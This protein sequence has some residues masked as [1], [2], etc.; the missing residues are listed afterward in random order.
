MGD[1]KPVQAVRLE[2]GREGDQVWLQ[3]ST[4]GA[5]PIKIPIDAQAAFEAAEKLAR[6][7]HIAR[8]GEPLKSDMSYLADQIKRRVTEEFRMFLVQRISVMLNSLREDKSWSNGKLAGE[9]VDT[10]LTKVA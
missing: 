3:L 10:V 7:A 9:L 1:A 8:F 2:I 4:N 5:N 6:A